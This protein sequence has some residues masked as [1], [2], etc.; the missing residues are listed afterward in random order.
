MAS[1]GPVKRKSMNDRSARDRRGTEKDRQTPSQRRIKWGIGYLVTG[2]LAAWLLQQVVLSPSLSQAVEIP[3]SDFKSKLVAGQIVNVTLGDTI[4]GAMKNPAQTPPTLPF[5]AVAPPSGDPDLLRELGAAHVTYRVRRSSSPVGGF[6]LQW[7]LPLMVLAALWSA[8]SRSLG[9]RMG[10]GVLGV[11]KSK[12]TEVKAEEVGVTFKDVGGAD[13]AI[14]E[15]HEIIQFLKTPQRFARLGGRIPKGVLLVGPP[16]TGKTLIAK[17]TAGEAGVRF[18]ETSGS[19]FVEMFV[20]V[21]AARVRDLFDQARAAAPAIV[22]IDEI[23]A[24]GRT[25]GGAIALGANDEREQTL[26]QLLAEIDGFKADAANPVIIMAAT[27]R[28][29][30]LDPALLRAGRFDRQVVLGNPDLAGRLQILRIHS[31]KIVLAPDFDQERAARVTPGFSGADLANVIN[32]AALLSARRNA[33]AVLFVDFEAA[34]ERVMGGLEQRTRVM[35]ARERETVAYH[36]CGHA[37]VASLVPK[38]DPVSKIS[39]IP[40][41]RGALGYTMQMPKEDRYLLATEELE[42]QLAVMM[43]GRAA[44]HL[45]LGTI[46]TGA[47]DDIQRATQL[48]KRMVTEFGMS[49]KLGSVRYAGHGLRYLGGAIDEGSDI[50]AETKEMIDAE[51]RRIVGEQFARAEA[52]LTAHRDALVRLANRL[53]E[54]ESLDGSAVREILGQVPLTQTT[55]WRRSAA[56][57]ASGFP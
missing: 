30:V 28:P 31:A 42:D 2:L 36:E 33:D 52:L 56:I 24:I 18:F 20:G 29:E 50:S 47:A 13:E 6:L 43:G 46:S 9:T 3:Y 45:I 38:G 8:A 14:A 11:G 32:E 25:R 26:N 23:D 37:L 27:N 44:E 16:G 57:V 39:I 12:A 4:E 21:G 51:V 7:L 1:N 48:A 41:S 40:R 34:I 5:V 49:E 15:L 53:L 22:F 35:N 54:S 10:G 19:E 17:A 55:S